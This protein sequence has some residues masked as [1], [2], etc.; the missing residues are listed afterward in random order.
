MASPSSF[1]DGAMV[2]VLFFSPPAKAPHAT[3]A[4]PHLAV[5][6]LRCMGHPSRAKSPHKHGSRRG[7]RGQAA[8]HG[9]RRDEASRPVVIAA[10]AT[11]SAQPHV[12]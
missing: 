5:H 2:Q 4:M 8:V 10:W 12:H 7:D 11:A 9:R 1:T 3:V 6:G